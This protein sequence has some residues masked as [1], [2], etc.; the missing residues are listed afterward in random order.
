[1]TI[2]LSFGI[3]EAVRKGRGKCPKCGK[4]GLGRANH[5]H[6]L[7]HKVLDK[8]HCRYCKGYFRKKEAPAPQAEIKNEMDSG[9]S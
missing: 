5:P 7:G 1:M 8:F 9:K 2:Q 6:A 4:K 3:P